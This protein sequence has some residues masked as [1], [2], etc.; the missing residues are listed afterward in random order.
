L[1]WVQLH[2]SLQI[3]YITVHVCNFCI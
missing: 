3:L 1:W 2:F